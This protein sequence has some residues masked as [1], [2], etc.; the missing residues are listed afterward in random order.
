MVVLHE[1]MLSHF[2]CNQRMGIVFLA[3]LLLQGVMLAR[4]SWE[5]RFPGTYNGISDTYGRRAYSIETLDD[6][7][8]FTRRRMIVFAVWTT[9]LVLVA[10]LC[11]ASR[12]ETLLWMDR[13]F[14]TETSCIGPFQAEYK[15]D[16]AQVAIVH[17]SE[18]EWLK[19]PSRADNYLELS[20][21]GKSRKLFIQL[22]GRQNAPELI[23][24]APSAMRHY[25]DYLRN[26][27]MAR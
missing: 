19:R 18:S 2:S 8:F 21:P 27:G 9:I 13:G 16:R 5:V 12:T 14:I 10:A 1:G 20:E 11:M 4:L 3:A 7:P 26:P 6:R 22:K 17:K 25:A 15:L 23:A 24:L